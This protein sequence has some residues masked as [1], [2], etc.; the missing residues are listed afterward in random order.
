VPQYRQYLSPALCEIFV[1]I[2]E[3]LPL[4]QELFVTGED[5]VFEI[6]SLLVSRDAFLPAD[7]SVLVQEYS[8]PYMHAHV[9]AVCALSLSSQAN[10]AIAAALAAPISD[11][12]R[13]WPQRDKACRVLAK[14]ASRL[15]FDIGH[16]YFE[17]LLDQ[18]CCEMGLASGHWFVL[19]IGT[20]L[21][22]A[23]AADSG[24]LIKG[25]NARLEYYIRL[26]TPGFQ[27]LDGAPEPAVLMLLGILEN[28]SDDTPRRVQETVVD[29][30]G[31]VYWNLK[32]NGAKDR[33][34][35]AG[36]RLA[37]D[38]R[39]LLAFSFEPISDR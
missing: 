4:A 33:L 8:A 9:F 10:E 39:V 20:S 28:V 7:P 25:D 24:A 35:C 26:M 17:I 12:T 23:L 14:L 36:Q 2:L 34:L 38:L 16:R 13:I 32:L 29:V 21:L 1:R 27:K 37:S 22:K 11:M 15:A 30:V 31:M 5:N 18:P 6:T 19:N 3:K